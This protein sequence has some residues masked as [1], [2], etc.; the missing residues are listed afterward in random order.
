M[1]DVDLDVVAQAAGALNPR[2][3]EVQ[4]TMGRVRAAVQ[5]ECPAMVNLKLTGIVDGQTVAV[6]QLNKR[7]NWLLLGMEPQNPNYPKCPLVGTDTNRCQQLVDAFVFTDALM[8]DRVFEKVVFSAFLQP[9]EGSPELEWRGENSVGQLRILSAEDLGGHLMSAQQV[10]DVFLQG[11]RQNCVNGTQSMN[12]Q[13]DSGEALVSHGAITCGE[14]QNPE[15]THVVVAQRG[16][17]IAAYSLVSKSPDF[18]DVDRLADALVQRLRE[19][20]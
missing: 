13:P 3:R 19:I 8:A 16:G 7:V 4:Q 18:G 9:I 6:F 14:A 12:S 17:N 10:V 2:D 20:Y 1:P 11:K 5:H 15:R